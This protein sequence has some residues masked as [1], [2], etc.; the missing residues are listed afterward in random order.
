LLVFAQRNIEEGDFES[1]IE[2]LNEAKKLRTNDPRLYELLGIAYDSERDSEK[3]FDYYR[4]SGELYFKSGNIDRAW[5]ML[6][7]MRTAA[8]NQEDRD[9]I[10]LFEKKL[11]ERQL[12]L[13]KERFEKE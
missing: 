12:I 9:Q 13:N 10:A 8:V 6:G 11:R 1:A 5:T 2:N 7:W 3:A 4:R